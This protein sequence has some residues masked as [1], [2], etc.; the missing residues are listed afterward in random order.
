[1]KKIFAF[2]ILTL[3]LLL[4]IGYVYNH[5]NLPDFLYYSSDNKPSALQSMLDTRI[6]ESESLKSIKSGNSRFILIQKP[7]SYHIKY[8]I[9]AA[10][11]LG[12][13]LFMLGMVSNLANQSSRSYFSRFIVNIQIIAVI[14]ILQIIPTA[15]T[16]N[17]PF[18]WYVIQL[19]DVGVIGIIIC[20]IL[21][22]VVKQ[23]PKY[24]V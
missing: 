7:S 3:P 2:V 21:S 24:K 20:A 14:A 6:G 1:M 10:G 23:K 8:L 17:L 19:I 22:G 12:I 11:V 15:V 18:K 16:E 4:G 9:P 5:F 13:G